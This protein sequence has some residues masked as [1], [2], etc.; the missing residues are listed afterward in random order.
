MTPRLARTNAEEHLYMQLHPCPSC[1]AAGFTA[2][3]AV[4]L[5]EGVLAS[6][7][8]GP[9]PGCGQAREFVFRLPDE[10][11]LPDPDRVRF[12]RDGEPSELIDAGEWLWV[13]DQIARAV[14]ADLSGLDEP[15]RTRAR[16]DLS[17][18]VAAM[19]E[20]LKFLPEGAD[21]VPELACWTERG[22]LL[23]EAEP[24]R[25]RRSRL[26]A[27]RASYLDLRDRSAG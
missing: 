3:S 1:G 19:D 15:D 10:I 14:P 20:V 11:L 27:R 2:P 7:F 16:T 25:F 24:A 23:Y 4:V 5:V 17:A 6:R 12:G 18:A 26:A 8:A 9:C 22:R 21:A 13:A